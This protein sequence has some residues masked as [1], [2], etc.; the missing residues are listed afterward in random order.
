MR[1]NLSVSFSFLATVTFAAGS[2]GAIGLT[3]G[4]RTE[5]NPVFDF[6]GEVDMSVGDF[7]RPDLTAIDLAGADLTDLATDLRMDMFNADLSGPLFKSAVNYPVGL[8]PF[9]MASGDV[10]KDGFR[11]LVVVV[12]GDPMNSLGGGAIPSSAQVLLGV[13]DGTFQAVV[14]YPLPNFPRG[15]RI[16]DMDGDINADLVVV[17]KGAG[18][19]FLKGV[20][21]GTFGAVSSYAAGGSPNGLAIADIDG[22]GRQDAVV[23]NGATG[24]VAV[25]LG[26]GSGA[27]A[28]A[29]EFGVKSTAADRFPLGV[30]VGDMNGDGKQDI[31]TVNVAADFVTGSISFITNTSTLGS[32]SFAAPAE[33]P[34]AAKPNA[35]LVAQLDGSNKLDVVVANTGAKSIDVLLSNNGAIG[36]PTFAAPVPYA[37][38]QSPNAIAFGDIDGDGRVDL[39]TANVES[40]VSVLHGLVGGGAFGRLETFTARGTPAAVV[41]GTFNGDVKLDVATAN[42]TTNDISVLLNQR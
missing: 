12:S 21:N 3:S 42:Q 20:G 5:D 25:L 26:N 4:C 29:V 32:V 41:T 40:S 9:Y 33:T 28:A 7:A 19:G 23:S 8:G 39:V 14:T 18:V 31:V 2:L 35:V 15:V 37:L 17:T 27:F 24:Q 1:T 36:A 22:D 10:N 13:G 11:D 16:I 34:T 6:S 38:G 30:A